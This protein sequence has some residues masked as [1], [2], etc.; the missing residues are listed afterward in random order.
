MTP[1]P[2]RKKLL[3]KWF[4]WSRKWAPQISLQK[5]LTTHHGIPL[6]FSYNGA[7]TYFVGKCCQEADP[8][9]CKVRGNK[10]TSCWFP[11]SYLPQV[12]YPSRHG[13]EMVLLDNSKGFPLEVTMFLQF[14]HAWAKYKH[15]ISL[16]LMWGFWYVCRYHL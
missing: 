10:S 5:Q 4:L 6:C 7:V 15:C 14:Y 16:L 8:S 12:G 1:N 3:N 13:D 11:L 9:L 2:Q